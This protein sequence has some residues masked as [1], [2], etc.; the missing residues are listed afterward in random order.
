MKSVIA[1]SEHVRLVAEMPAQRESD[2]ITLRARMLSVAKRLG[3][4]DARCSDM[5]LV[6]YELATNISKYAQGK[7][8][9]QVWLQPGP[10]IDIFAL[11]YGPGIYE[12]ERA[13][14]NGYST[15]GTLGKGL[16]SIA[17]LC[18]HWD[19]YSRSAPP[20]GDNTNWHGTAV[21]ARFSTPSLLTQH[22][23]GIYVR[24]LNDDSYSG[25]T[26]FLYC[27][28]QHIRWFHAD[29]LGS[30]KTAQQSTEPLGR[31][32]LHSPRPTEILEFSRTLIE[33]GRGAVAI[34][35]AYQP[36]PGQ[37]VVCGIGDMHLDVCNMDSDNKDKEQ[38]KFAPGILGKDVYAATPHNIT[39]GKRTAVLS[40]SDGIRRNWDPQRYAG[41]MSRDPQLIAYF[42]GS[43]AGRLYDDRSLFVLSP[44]RCN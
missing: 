25:D 6:V 31:A 32:L 35:G 30:G 38:I 23:I 13:L 7:G 17:R 2:R 3:Y 16:G 14:G 43:E 36:H 15:S 11:D 28:D 29:G 39:M 12:L 41:L 19:I 40:A 1:S 20:G 10:S 4:G 5:S 44:P 37:L 9:I 18:D 21:L 22:G 27:N 8:F 24:S 34:V 26:I 42:L 33:S